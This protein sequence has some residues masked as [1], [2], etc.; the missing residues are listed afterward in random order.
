MVPVSGGY[1]RR[2]EASK[3][4][5][6]Q[7]TSVPC[8]GN[9]VLAD[10]S[11]ATDNGRCVRE[12][13][14]LMPNVR[15]NC[16]ACH[17]DFSVPN[18]MVGEKG[19]CPRCREILKIENASHKTT[20]VWIRPKEDDAKTRSMPP[21][22]FPAE[23]S[24]ARQPRPAPFYYSCL[25]AIF[26]FILVLSCGGIG[27]VLLWKKEIPSLQPTALEERTE[28]IDEEE[29]AIQRKIKRAS[30][31][32]GTIRFLAWGPHETKGELRA[33]TLEAKKHSDAW[34]LNTNL[35]VRLRE[36]TKL[37]RVRWSEDS[38]EGMT[39]TR[40]QIFYVENGVVVISDPN[41][42]GADWLRQ[43]RQSLKEL[44]GQ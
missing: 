1:E 15:C 33:L 13:L 34:E 12:R 6:R 27:V 39:E 26:G 44:I 4:A 18:Y 19:R 28:P 35:Q 9:F 30:A 3:S 23:P 36:D 22:A 17:R 8:H 16:P 37:Y 24:P 25:A 10:N 7:Y 14:V 43:H 40:D 31:H 11:L 29:K 41:P 5:G 2:R 42:L 21:E 32:P 20:V 38:S